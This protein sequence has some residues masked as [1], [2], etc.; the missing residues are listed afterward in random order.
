MPVTLEIGCEEW[1][2]LATVADA[3]GVG[4]TRSVVR[5]RRNLEDPDFQTGLSFCSW[6]AR[7]CRPRCWAGLTGTATWM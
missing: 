5:L 3:I 4:E 2:T 6:S 1:T 7:S